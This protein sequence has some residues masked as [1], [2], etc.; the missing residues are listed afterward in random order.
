MKRFICLFVYLFIFLICPLNVSAE[1]L[2]KE[3]Q[4]LLQQ[5]ALAEAENQG[6]G[7]MSFVMQ[8]VLNRVVSDDFPDTVKKV[9]EEEGQFQVA[10]FYQSIQPTENS[11]KALELLEIL[12]NKGQLYFE[13]THGKKDTWHSRNLELV[14]KY[15][16]HTFYK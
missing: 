13:N 15:E 7:G 16:Q 9:I 2:T 8:V 6:I 12:E 5:V 10:S 3:D 14:F 1:E 11:E 4:I